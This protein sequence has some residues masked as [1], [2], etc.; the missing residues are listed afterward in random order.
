MISLLRREFITTLGAG[1]LGIK[2]P[3]FS[4]SNDK[5]WEEK[6]YTFEGVPVTEYLW[7][8]DRKIILSIEPT[9]EEK[10]E[11]IIYS[12]WELVPFPLHNK[13]CYTTLEKELKSNKEY[14]IKEYKNKAFHL[15]VVKI[16]DRN[17]VAVQPFRRKPEVCLDMFTGYQESFESFGDKVRDAIR[18]LS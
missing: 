18:K 11:G 16:I 1:L 8:K 9:D 6:S 3:K 7:P 15:V 2:L 12:N 10:S 14:G 4:E 5:W 13:A 17:L